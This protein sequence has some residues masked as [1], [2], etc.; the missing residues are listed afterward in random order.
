[1][2]TGSD[3]DDEDDDLRALEALAGA[4][5]GDAAEDD[6]DDEGKIDIGAM[7]VRSSLSR[8]PD[9]S[10]A[11][12][13]E[14]DAGEADAADRDASPEVDA[15]ARRATRPETGPVSEAPAAGSSPRARDGSRLGLGLALGFAVGIGSGWLAFATPTTDLAAA[16][17]GDAAAIA[18]APRVST[19]GA[20]GEQPTRTGPAHP[21]AAAHATRPANPAGPV[22]PPDADG[23]V[24]GAPVPV[25]AVGAGT[26]SGRPPT[27]PTAGP[28]TAPTHLPP[29][30]AAKPAS[31]T[32]NGTVAAASPTPAATNPKPATRARTAKAPPAKPAGDAD[33]PAVHTAPEPAPGIDALLDEALVGPGRAAPQA[34]AP[35]LPET[36][37]AADVT[38]A[39]KVLVPAIRGC[40][41]GQQG[42]AVLSL[43]VGSDGRVR[44][45]R[46][47]GAPFV[48][49]AAGTC[50]EGVARRARF[51][52]FARPTFRVQLPLQLR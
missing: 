42:V 36:P 47:E 41:G 1:M 20:T 24:D 3:R 19:P 26:A 10:E 25:G 21:T 40:A 51:P 30:P 39:I 27:L 37:S 50:M 32:G 18:Q 14:A 29:D 46:I 4:T 49:T 16:P 45:A 13:G 35:A 28:A 5:D 22:A 2:V 8:A 34:S 12:A 31:A 52:R 33:K 6:E 11:D 44:D 15:Q 43:V 7:L 17:E 9:T 38:G 23:Q 48:G